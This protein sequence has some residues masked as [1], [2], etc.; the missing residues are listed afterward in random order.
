M[1]LPPEAIADLEVRSPL[2]TAATL[3]AVASNGAQT[4]LAVGTRGGAVKSLNGGQC[5]TAM[6]PCAA[7]RPGRTWTA[8]PLT[9]P[10]L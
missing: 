1:A 6:P 5:W 3:E 10:D 9:E 4:L 2:P 7:T 8:W